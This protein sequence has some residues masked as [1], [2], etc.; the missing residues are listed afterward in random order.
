MAGGKKLFLSLDE[1]TE[2]FQCSVVSPRG[3]ECEQMVEGGEYYNDSAGSAVAVGHVDVYWGE[4]Q[5]LF[6]F[7]HLFIYFWL[8]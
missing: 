5:V 6:L 3:Q 8:Y 4:S 1:Q 2:A 7:I